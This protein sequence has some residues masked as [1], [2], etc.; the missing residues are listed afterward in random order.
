MRQPSLESAIIDG[1]ATEAFHVFD[2]LWRKNDLAAVLDTCERLMTF[3]HPNVT[4]SLYVP[5]VPVVRESLR[6]SLTILKSRVGYSQR[7]SIDGQTPYKTAHDDG[8]SM[9]VTAE[10]KAIATRVVNLARLLPDP[11]QMSYKPCGYCNGTGCG[12][13]RISE[14]VRGVGL[15]PCGGCHGT[16]TVLVA[17]PTHALALC[18][19][20]F[21][22]A[23]ADGGWWPWWC[24]SIPQ[25][26][27]PEGVT[28][29][30]V[31]R[32]KRSTGVMCLRSRG[33]TGHRWVQKIG[34]LVRATG[35]I[36]CDDICP[37]LPVL[38]VS[39]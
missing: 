6:H 13:G 36:E 32:D 3:A 34:V 9:V 4:P 2:S 11:Q 19:D 26:P 23:K 20:A 10:D 31:S 37:P 15:P 22:L 21:Q 39:P 18:V 38:D 30:W 8:L 28:Y 25:D 24:R 12:R 35:V 17:A 5:F 1:D 14:L 27:N 7:Y 33:H 16:G 29:W